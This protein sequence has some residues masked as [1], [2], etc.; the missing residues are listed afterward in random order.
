MSTMFIFRATE[1]RDVVYALLAIAMDVTPVADATLRF[2]YKISLVLTLLNSFLED[3]PFFIDFNRPYSDVCR[4]FIQFIIRRKYKLDPI[5]S[6]D[7]LCQ[8]WALEPVQRRSI[9]L[10]KEAIVE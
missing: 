10:K 9:R 4:D 2:D 3:K 6:L 7:I 1:P 8:P 5:Q